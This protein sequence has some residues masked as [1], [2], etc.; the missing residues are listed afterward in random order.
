LCGI[1]L[2]LPIL[3]PICCR[4]GLLLWDARAMR[5]AFDMMLKPIHSAKSELLGMID[6]IGW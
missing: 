2:T 3:L 6:R 5:A 4:I 1:V